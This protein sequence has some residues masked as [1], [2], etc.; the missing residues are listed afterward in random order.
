MQGRLQDHTGADLSSKNACQGVDSPFYD[1]YVPSKDVI[2]VVKSKLI[3]STE[4]F[5]I[6]ASSSRAGANSAAQVLRQPRRIG[7]ELCCGSAG[8]TAAIVDAGWEGIGIDYN[9]AHK[10]RA[11]WLSIDLTS[12]AGLRQLFQLLDDTC[13]AYVHMGL[14]CGTYS[15]AREIPIPADLIAQGAFEPVPLRSDDFPEGLPDLGA[16]EQRRVDQANLLTEMGVRVALACLKKGILWTIENPRSSILW[17]VKSMQEL[18][19]MEG[20]RAVDGQMCMFEGGR[21][22]WFRLV[23]NFVELD[24][25]AK[26]CDGG[27]QHRPWGAR[28]LDGKWGFHIKEEAEYTWAFSKGLA[29][30]AIAA[31][32]RLHLEGSSARL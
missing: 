11:P 16:N 18:M 12:G 28:Y 29:G 30:A 26:T 27:H 10:A 17:L 9:N 8:L 21:N 31:A 24:C 19:A 20:V 7:I 32:Q 13:V 22:K 1:A 5:S 4:K 14:P 23:G 3:S 2:G 15:R 6:S 25:M